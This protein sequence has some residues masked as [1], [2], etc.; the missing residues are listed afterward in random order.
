[1]SLRASVTSELVFEDCR[2]PAANILPGSDGLK[3]PLLCLDRARYGIAWGDIGAAMACYEAAV[4]YARERIQ[5]GK[6]IASFQLVQQKL[7]FMLT[8]I[9][10]AQLLC[11]RVGRRTRTVRHQQI[12]MAKINSIQIALDIARIARDIHGASGITTEYPVIRHLCNLESV[13]TYE[14]THDIHILIL[15][16]DITGIPAFS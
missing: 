6:P 13:N 2:I 14:G 16:N 1:M 3:S 15:G 4:A 9:S 11:W 12:S 10:K 8:E 5:F 7:V